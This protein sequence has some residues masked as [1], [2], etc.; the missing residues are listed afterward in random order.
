M[1]ESVGCML[2]D[3]SWMS[4]PTRASH[5]LALCSEPGLAVDRSPIT[6]QMRDL[7]LEMAHMKL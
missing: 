6:R 4:V 7:G 2:E 3:G 1:F 5:R